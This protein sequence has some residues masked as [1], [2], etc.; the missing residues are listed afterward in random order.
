MASTDT[1]LLAQLATA[2]GQVRR[3]LLPVALAHALVA[4][5]LWQQGVGLAAA[6]WWC[7]V[8]AVNLARSARARRLAA[9]APAPAQLR[10]MGR[11]LLL[12]GLLE[13][14]PLLLCA[15]Y[16][17][18]ESQYLVS[19]VL[20]GLTVGGVSNLA[21]LLRLYLLWAL[22]LCATLAG[23]WLAR[24]GP[25]G[26][27][28]AL[29]VLLF[30]G[31]LGSYVRDYGALLR[32]EREAA[33]AL[34]LERDRATA[35]VHARSQFFMAASH[36]LRQPLGAIRWYGEAVLEHARQLQ[37]DTLADIGAGLA[38]AVARTE[39]MLAQLLEVGQLDAPGAA[40]GPA[41]AAAPVAL[42]GLLQSLAEA[43]QPEAQTRGLALTLEIDPQL[44]A[45]QVHSS[46]AGLRR[47][48]DNIIG[49][50]F[51]F[52]PSGEVSL[53]LQRVADAAA[54]AGGSPPGSGNPGGAGSAGLAGGVGSAGSAGRVRLSVRD[55]GIGIAPEHLP[56][57]FDD[58]YQVPQAGRSAARGV[59]LGLAIA[60]RHAQRL[61]LEL[62]VH[63]V[64]GQGSCFACE[65][66]LLAV[67]AAVPLSR[68]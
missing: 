66:P 54:P 65:L 23:L 47:I 22:P 57:L 59:G 60:R 51:K 33:T 4:G 49:N 16:A 44:D 21:G 63:S 10:S 24:G 42:S 29:L 20:L 14:V 11:W 37:H 31:L 25:E 64:P 45:P 1:A 68:P 30:F 7:A 8:T 32:R 34:R 62:Q 5:L 18:Q 46:E 55:T 19:M 61:G 53:S 43:W 6:A 40:E 26:W 58:F 56:R 9:Q 12:M 15:G 13:P 52:T 67:A 3:S 2:R 17:S 50:A 36:D 41:E 28:I 39:P 48:F 38:R 27:G 35:A